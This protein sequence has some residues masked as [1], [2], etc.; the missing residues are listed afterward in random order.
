MRL[1][2]EREKRS[3]ERRVDLYT[4]RE[5]I[6]IHAYKNMCIKYRGIV[7][8]SVYMY[9]HKERPLKYRI[10]SVAVSVTKF[11]KDR[12]TDWQ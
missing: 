7:N 4:E 6:M 1:R 2:R 11:M 9:L 10:Q 5:H 12:Q 3:K 8:I